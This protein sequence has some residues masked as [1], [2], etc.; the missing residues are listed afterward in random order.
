M[1]SF[2][3]CLFLTALRKTFGGDVYKSITLVLELKILTQVYVYVQ[4]H[5]NV[6]IKLEQYLNVNS[7]LTKP[8]GIQI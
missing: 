7:T 4:I 1:E 6:D 8:K 3:H 2:S 5:K